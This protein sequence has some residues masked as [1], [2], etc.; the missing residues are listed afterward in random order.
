MDCEES[1]SARTVRLSTPDDIDRKEVRYNESIISRISLALGVT[2]R[3]KKYMA[4]TNKSKQ[5]KEPGVSRAEFDALAKGV[6]DLVD[7]IKGGALQAPHAQTPSEI[8]QNKEIEKA[9]PNKYTVNPEWEEMAREII[10]E[11]VDHTEIA[12][13][14]GGGLLFTVVIKTE[15][16]NAPLDY[17]AMYKSD[18]RTREVGTEGEAGVRTWCELIKQNLKRE[19]AYVSN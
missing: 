17:L 4:A 1:W 16:S 9:S 10:G 15:M 18:R 2:N 19:R 11:A 13:G 7:L 12:Y 3:R 14:K 5:A 8:I 6:G